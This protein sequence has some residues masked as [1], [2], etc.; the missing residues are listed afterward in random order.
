ML[1]DL[2]RSFPSYADLLERLRRGERP[3]V[4]GGAGA[5]PAILLAALS[6]DLQRPFAIVVPD[7]KASAS[8]TG[9]L[10]AAGLT[11]VFHAPAPTLTPYQRIPPSLKSRRDEFGLLSALQDPPAVGAGGLPARGR[12]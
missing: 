6:T 9:D 7:E 10:G 5:I 11:R 12:V 3:V 8:L 4:A 1:T 2:V